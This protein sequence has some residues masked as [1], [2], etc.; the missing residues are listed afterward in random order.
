MGKNHQNFQIS[1]IDDFYPKLPNLRG[2]HRSELLSYRP[3]KGTNRKDFVHTFTF[4]NLKLRQRYLRTSGTSYMPAK[5]KIST[6][7][8]LSR[9]IGKLLKKYCIKTFSIELT[10]FFSKTPK[11]VGFLKKKVRTNP[12]HTA[13]CS[14]V[15]N[16]YSWEQVLEKKKGIL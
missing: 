4:L 11:K 2:S 7:L 10:L 3:P 12:T 9:Y 5:I 8:S 13:L 6:F 16:C 1:K 14:S 15:P